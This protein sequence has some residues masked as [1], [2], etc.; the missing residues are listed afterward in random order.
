MKREIV[1]DT[2]T[3]GLDP[4]AGHRMVEIGCVEVVGGIRTGSYFHA[5][6][7]PERD[8][9]AEAFRVHGISS[10]FLKDKPVFAQAVDEF[11]AFIRQDTLVIHN[12]GFD[13][14]FLNF[15]LERLGFPVLPMSRATDTVLLA[16]RKFPGA[17]ASLDALCR[18]FNIDTSQRTRHGALLDAEL[19]AEVYLELLG[20]RQ[21]TLA[22]DAQAEAEKTVPAFETAAAPCVRVEPR[23][24]PLTAAEEQAHAALLAQLKNPLWAAFLP[25]E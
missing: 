24:F 1:L 16:R 3:T 10:D 25:A 7:N 22:L 19:L 23:Q 9:P 18:R 5:Y 6:L 4:A 15:E 12:A 13:M 21:V 17:P 14:K 11:L 20:G 2:E 8:M